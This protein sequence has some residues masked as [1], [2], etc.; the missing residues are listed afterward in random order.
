MVRTPSAGKRAG[1]SS[2]AGRATTAADPSPSARRG[3][4]AVYDAG[5]GNVLLFGGNNIAFDLNETWIWNG[6]NWTQLS[7]PNSATAR[8][9]ANLAYDAARNVVVMFGGDDVARDTWTWNGT[10]WTQV[11]A[12]T[13]APFAGSNGMA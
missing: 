6:V 2:S 4:S 9:Y 5:R 7:P 12:N 10:T 1:G 8:S 13:T 3:A 11:A